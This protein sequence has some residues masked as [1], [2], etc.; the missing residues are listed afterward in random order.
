V[1]E[2]LDLYEWNLMQRGSKMDSSE[3]EW[4]ANR[5][6]KRMS[7]ERFRGEVKKKSLTLYLCA[8]KITLWVSRQKGFPK[9]LKLGSDVDF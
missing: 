9:S 5:G 7:S 2:K 8:L 1:V 3:T 6:S 4:S